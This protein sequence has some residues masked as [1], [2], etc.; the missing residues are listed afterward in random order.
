[1]NS[2]IVSFSAT[3]DSLITRRLPGKDE[4][5]IEIQSIINKSDVKFTN[6]ETTLYNPESFPSAVS[7]GSWC[8]SSPK[9]LVD[10]LSYGFNMISWANNHTLDFSYGGLIATANFLDQQGI[11]HAG[12]G[13]N[14]ASASEPKYLETLSG[15][16]A[17][18]AATANFDRTWIA[19]DQRRDMVGRPGIN[20]L[21]LNTVYTLEYKYME[22]LKEIAD[23]CKINSAYKILT[24]KKYMNKHPEIYFPFGENL[25]KVGD[26]GAVNTQVDPRDEKRIIS[27]INEAKRQSDYII[28]SIHSHQP[29]EDNFEEP[30]D[31][32]IDFSK[33]CIDAGAHAIICHGPHILRGIEIYKDVPIFYSLGNFIF[34][35]ESTTIQPS[36]FY[37]KFGLGNENNV[38]DA[39]D[40]ENDMEINGLSTDP[41]VWKSVIPCWRMKK[42][43]LI[44][45][46]LYPIELGFSKER[47]SRGWPRI[48]INSNIIENLSILSEKFGTKIEIIDGIGKV[49]L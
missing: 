9:A 2:N 49:T 11:V 48:A 44:E 30:P 1:M 5:Y 21:R 37:N 42:G 18:I 17:L 25:F 24:E 15:R 6:L 12:A 40:K 45:L 3:G 20:P 10:L 32:I 4:D 23:S 35:H 7:G 28:V 27:S 8:S 41:Q 43:K 22:I 16:V 38:A 31:F 39:F 13:N 14:L 36:D 47:Y 34:Q 33:R 29:N 26:K 46:Y 19:G